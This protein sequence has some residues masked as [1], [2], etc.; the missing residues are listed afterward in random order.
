M[1]ANQA[2]VT[3]DSAKAPAGLTKSGTRPPITTTA[4]RRKDSGAL[5]DLD[6]ALLEAA[7]ELDFDWPEFL[8]V[9][10]VIW[11]ITEIA[12]GCALAAGAA[13]FWCVVWSDFLKR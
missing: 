13:V 12:V 2:Y 1:T 8:P 9:E 4:P 6:R 7:E 11:G 5:Y 10:R 3:C